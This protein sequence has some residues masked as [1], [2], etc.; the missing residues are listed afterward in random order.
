MK[1]FIQEGNFN[2]NPKIRIILIKILT[3]LISFLYSKKI[4]DAT[5][6]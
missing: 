6:L 3:F 4:N 1:R 5:W 2:N